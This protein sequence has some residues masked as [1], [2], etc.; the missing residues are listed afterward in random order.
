VAEGS[1]W[2]SPVNKTALVRELRL[3]QGVIDKGTTIPVLSNVLL[4]AQGEAL[5]L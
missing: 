5:A 2:N 1:A 3:S 4:E